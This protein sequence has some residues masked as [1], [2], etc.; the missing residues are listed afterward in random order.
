[1][2]NSSPAESIYTLSLIL[3]ALN[4]RKIMSQRDAFPNTK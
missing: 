1:M 4:A 3:R 2:G